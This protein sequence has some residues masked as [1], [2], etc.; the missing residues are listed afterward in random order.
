MNSYKFLNIIDFELKGGTGILQ[1]GPQEDLN[2]CN[3]VPSS[4]GKRAETRRPN[5]GDGGHRRRGG[6]GQ[7]GPGG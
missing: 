7:E 5:S 4:S 3:Q 6:T 1:P 2:Q